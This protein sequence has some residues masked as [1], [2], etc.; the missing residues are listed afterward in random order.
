MIKIS[1]LVSFSLTEVESYIK[2]IICGLEQEA[3]T[4]STLY[5]CSHYTILKPLFKSIISF[6]SHESPLKKVIFLCKDEQLEA[7]ES[8]NNL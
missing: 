3:T 1:E 2:E 7:R 4:T 8:K 5:L 6:N